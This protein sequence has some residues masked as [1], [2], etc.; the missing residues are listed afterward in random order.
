MYYL[1]KIGAIALFGF[2]AVTTANAAIITSNDGDTCKLGVDG[3]NWEVC[4]AITPHSAWQANNPLGRG[5]EWISIADTG[6]GGVVIG[7]NEDEE[8]FWAQEVLEIT[9]KS[10][11]TFDVWADD[12]AQVK[13][14][15]NHYSADVDIL[16]L[17]NFVQDGA[18]AA[19]SIGCE[20]GENGHYE[21]MLD[22]G[23][24]NL[25]VGAYQ[26]GGGPTGLL[27]S[28]EYS[29]VPEPASI[30]LLGLGLA[31]LGFARR[32]TKAS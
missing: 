1:K 4:Q 13:I 3:A 19:G 5:A 2:A 11:L 14:S 27:Y 15:Y 32:K 24:H 31:G 7:N 9:E 30:A 18:C 16:T 12:T 10:L 20:P 25:F 8:Y 21:I 22:V 6:V 17:G 28:G 23:T 29:A 26:T